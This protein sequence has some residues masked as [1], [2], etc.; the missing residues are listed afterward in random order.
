MSL[1]RID[2]DVPDLGHARTLAGALEE[3][4]VPAPD[5]VTV[6]ETGPRAQRVSAYFQ[7]EPEC[8]AVDALVRE[9]FSVETAEALVGSKVVS[10]VPDENWVAVSQAALPP[11]VAGPFT[12]HGSHDRHRVPC[13]PL[14]IE[15]DAGEAFGT[16]HHATTLGC[17]NAIGELARKRRFRSVLDLGCGSGV[18]AIA[19]A[20]VMPKARVLATDIDPKATEVARQNVRRNRIAAGR[21]PVTTAD[22]LAHPALRGRAFELIIANILANPLIAL[23]NGLARMSPPRGCLVLSGLL[24]PQAPEVIAAYRAAGFALVDH[25]RIVGWSTLTLVKR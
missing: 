11:V 12:V 10:Q 1:Y 15:I 17:L 7:S 9:V 14:A 16:A 25:K 4:L 23:A 20:R 24:V 19:A 3:L 6:F 13:G 5:A 21:L 18:L 22:G 8:D 2:F